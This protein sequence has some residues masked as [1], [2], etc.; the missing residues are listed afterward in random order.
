MFVL[1]RHRFKARF[2][3]T[4]H[5]TLWLLRLRL[6]TLTIFREDL[7]EVDKC[8]L[9]VSLARPGRDGV[10]VVHVVATVVI[11]E[12]HIL[13][14][15][16]RN[17]VVWV[18]ILRLQD[19]AIVSMRKLKLL[20][21]GLQSEDW[22]TDHVHHIAAACAT[23]SYMEELLHVRSDDG[24]FLIH[25]G[26][27]V[28]AKIMTAEHNLLCVLLFL[29]E[30]RINKEDWGQELLVLWLKRLHALSL[31][32]IVSSRGNSEDGVL[33]GLGCLT[34]S[35]RNEF[36]THAEIRLLHWSHLTLTEGGCEVRELPS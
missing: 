36:F 33:D 2:F 35:K 22:S 18:L 7:S 21:A 20:N 10:W 1:F 6:G 9:L 17:A 27:L 8:V 31:F 16:M 24:P 15:E 12:V 23:R 13:Q 5:C 14:L 29:G 25:L 32:V 3:E 34:L 30:C 11:T 19:D 26:L 28:A 4:S